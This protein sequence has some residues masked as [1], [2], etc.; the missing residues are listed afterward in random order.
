MKRFTAVLFVAALFLAGPAHG[1]LFLKYEKTT[2]AYQIMGQTIPEK[3]VTATTWIGADKARFDDGEKMSAIMDGKAKTLTILDHGRKTYTII[4][5]DDKT[6]LM[7]KAIEGRASS[8]EEAAKMK[9]AMQG[10]MGAMKMQ[11]TVTPTGEKK[12]I[13]KWDCA[14]YDVNV[15][16]SMGNSKSEVWATEQIKIDRDRFNRVRN[17]GMA[18]QPGFEQMQKE[19]EKIKGVPVLSVSTA[20]VMN[21]E[22]KTTEKL[23]EQSEKSAPAGTY[24][25]PQGYKEQKGFG[26]DGGPMGAGDLDAEEGEDN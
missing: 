24:D 12:K 11:M 25:I 9:Q 22:V 1:D 13:D 15:S 19:A 18:G 17:F 4:P 23:V 7:D 20:K 21:A 14:R 2:G 26:G 8:P 3:K 5:L 10:M 16:M 6:S